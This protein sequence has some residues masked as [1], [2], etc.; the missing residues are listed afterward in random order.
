VGDQQ[1]R[2]RDRADGHAASRRE[3]I[4]PKPKTP[5]RSSQE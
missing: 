4:R 2:V 3:V 5:A 1:D